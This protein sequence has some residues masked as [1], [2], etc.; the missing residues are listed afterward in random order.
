MRRSRQSWSILGSFAVL[1]GLLLAP[2]C[3]TGDTQEGEQT[4]PP[5]LPDDE[6]AIEN[7]RVEP[8][9]AGSTGTLYMTIANGRQAADTLL[10]VRAPIVD[11]SAAYAP[12]SDTA[13]NRAMMDAL[14]IPART[15]MALRPDSAHVKLF[16]LGQSLDEGSTPILNLE[17]A[18]SGLQR[19][20][21]PVR[22]AP[23]ADQQ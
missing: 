15:R 18:Q 22:T 16:N 1:A 19:V 20:R 7:P 12:P 2:G 9:P 6:L 13:T 4:A 8:A 5:P 10:R 11:S 23:P 14:P 3:Q 17:F 21:V